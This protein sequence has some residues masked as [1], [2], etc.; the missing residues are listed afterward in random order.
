MTT[1]TRSRIRYVVT[2]D[3]FFIGYAD[4]RDGAEEV[5]FSHANRNRRS[6]D[7]GYEIKVEERKD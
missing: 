4:D 7:N 3:G 2:C 6:I 5:W 1:A